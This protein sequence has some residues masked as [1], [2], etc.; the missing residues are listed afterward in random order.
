MRDRLLRTEHFLHEKEPPQYSSFPVRFHAQERNPLPHCQQRHT[1]SFKILF[2]SIVQ[3][4]PKF[5]TSRTGIASQK[6]MHML[7][8]SSPIP[9]L[10][11]TGNYFLFHNRSLFQNT[12]HCTE[13]GPKSVVIITIEVLVRLCHRWKSTSGSFRMFRR[14][15]SCIGTVERALGW[16]LLD[17]I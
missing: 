4:D 17:A 6:S 12:G 9:M 14:Q 15:T 2:V 5:S 3:T 13:G 8:Q 1:I 10:L 7:A 16:P 11:K